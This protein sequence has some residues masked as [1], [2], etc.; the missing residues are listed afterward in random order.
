MLAHFLSASRYSTAVK[1]LKG[2]PNLFADR[3]SDSALEMANGKLEAVV[4]D[5]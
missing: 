5:C 3:S 2:N 1:K 4:I